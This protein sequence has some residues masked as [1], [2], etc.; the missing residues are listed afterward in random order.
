MTSDK[1]TAKST[2]ATL[3]QS[4]VPRYLQL[5]GLFR[6]KIETGEWQLNH[7][8]PTVEALSTEWGVARATIRQA[9]GLLDSEQLISRSRAKGSYVIKRPQDLLWLK[10]DTDWQGLLSQ[11][12]GTKI[13]VLSE[14]HSIVPPFIPHPIGTTTGRYRHI[15]R[16]HWRDDTPFLLA[17]VYIEEEIAAELSDS[18][19]KELTA[20]RLV[21]SVANISIKDA[22]Q[23]LTLGSADIETAELMKIPFNAPI[24]HVYRTVVDSKGRIV[25]I[26]NGTYRGDIVRI[27]MN[28]EPQS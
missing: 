13:E 10:V 27:D 19:F 9:L 7:Q 26:S 3:S 17:D 28:L 18:A 23:T 8:I 6:R 4:A 25:L 1:P 22:R 2:P 24:A 5:A 14:Q 15:R 12:D 21:T 20:L 11:R 16:R